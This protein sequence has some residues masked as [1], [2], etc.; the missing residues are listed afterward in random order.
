MRIKYF[1]ENY[2]IYQ[3]DLSNIGYYNHIGHLFSSSQELQESPDLE[4]N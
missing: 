3:K 2:F 1:I 4:A